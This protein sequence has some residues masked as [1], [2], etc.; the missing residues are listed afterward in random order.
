MNDLKSVCFHQ[1]TVSAQRKV[2]Q[3]EILQKTQ[4]VT[5]DIWETFVGKKKPQRAFSTQ[6]VITYCG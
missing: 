6:S 1:L 2:S 3:I 5:G 4:K